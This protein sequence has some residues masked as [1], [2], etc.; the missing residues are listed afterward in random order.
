[1]VTGLG[2]CDRTGSG[3]RADWAVR[4]G[5]DRATQPRRHVATA[6][7]DVSSAVAARRGIPG[8][9][10]A[11]PLSR[12]S[13]PS[14]VAA[15]CIALGG[16]VAAPRPPSVE[17]R[18]Q[19]LGVVLESHRHT[20]CVRADKLVRRLRA[21]AKRVD[22]F[23]AIDSGRT[24]DIDMKAA[25]RC[26]SAVAGRDV[27][28]TVDWTWTIERSGRTLAQGRS[29]IA[30]EVGFFRA[31]MWDDWA[32]MTLATLD[33]VLAGRD[34]LGDWNGHGMGESTWDRSGN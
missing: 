11:P 1:M 26:H 4:E 21:T 16:C 6:D 2:R 9:M 10:P 12:G 24:G 31:H 20:G 34:E 15:C 14:C 29:V 3:E 25:V 23:T 8:P 17:P 27:V 32:K 30:S 33:A 13:A 5:R 28:W 22:A 19:R 18:D 7:I